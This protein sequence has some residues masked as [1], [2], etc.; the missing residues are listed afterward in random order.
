MD[1]G[2]SGRMELVGGISSKG[3]AFDEGVKYRLVET[4]APAGSRR[5]TE[6]TVFEVRTNGGTSE[7]STVQVVP[8][9]GSLYI[10]DVP[11]DTT[12]FDFYKVDRRDKAPLAGASFSLTLDTSAPS[13]LKEGE[14][15]PEGSK[16]FSASS[17]SE[18]KVHFSGLYAGTY[19]LKETKAPEADGIQYVLNSSEYKVEV[20]EREDGKLAVHSDIDA[21]G[22][23]IVN[24]PEG[25]PTSLSITKRVAKNSDATDNAK[26]D[27]EPFKADVFNISIT[28]KDG[29]DITKE[30]TAKIGANGVERTVTPTWVDGSYFYDLQRDETLTISDIPAGEYTI[31]EYDNGSHQ[32]SF[33]YRGYPYLITVAGQET[34]LRQTNPNDWNSL[35][36]KDYG[37]AKVE[38]K[39]NEETKVEIVNTAKNS[40]DFSLRGLKKILGR[41]FAEG[42]DFDIELYNAR[43]DFSYDVADLIETVTASKDN[44]YSFG[45]TKDNTITDADPDG[46]FHFTWANYWDPELVGRS[47]D[48]WFALKEKD[49][50]AE[51]TDLAYD[52][53]VYFIKVTIGPDETGELYNV[54][55][56][57]KKNS[58]DAAPVA[59]G[60]YDSREGGVPE[61]VVSFTN[62]MA[63]GNLMLQKT[64]DG[65]G[66][67]SAIPAGKGA[68]GLFGFTV[69]GLNSSLG[70]ASPVPDVAEVFTDKDGQVV[71]GDITYTRVGT[72]YYQIS[73]TTVPAGFTKAADVYAKVEVTADGAT[74]ALTAV[75]SYGSE[76]AAA[77]SESGITVDN[78]SSYTGTRLTLNVEKVLKGAEPASAEGPFE[79]VLSEITEGEGVPDRL[80]EEVKVQRKGAG[81]AAFPDIRYTEPGTHYYTVTETQGERG[82]GA[83]YD[84]VYDKKVYTVKVAVEP[85]ATEEAGVKTYNVLNA[86]PS[87]EYVDSGSADPESIIA[88]SITFTNTKV[89]DEEIS[90]GVKKQINGEDFKLSDLDNAFS[91]TMNSS[92]VDKDGQAVSTGTETI[93]LGTDGTGGF[94]NA[95][96]TKEDI[97]KTFTYVIKEVNGEG[98]FD[99][100]NTEYTVN[101]AVGSDSGT[102]AI[103]LTKTLSTRKVASDGTETVTGPTSYNEAAFMLNFNNALQSV[104]TGFKAEKDMAGLPDG[105]TRD[106]KFSL[107]G[108]YSGDVPEVPSDSELLSST[109][110]EI[111]NG[112]WGITFKD[113]EGGDFEVQY[114]RAGIYKYLIT[115][116]QL[117]SEGKTKDVYAND[118]ALIV[119]VTVGD[120]DKDGRLDVTKVAENAKA[121]ASDVPV[122][123]N[124][125]SSDSPVIPVNKVLKGRNILDSDKFTFELRDSADLSSQ[126]LSALTVGTD[127]K[128][129]FKDFVTFNLNQAGKTFS[130]Y[131]NELNGG[132]RGVSYSNAVHQVDI[133]VG[134]N[135]STGELELSYDY[136]TEGDAGAVRFENVYTAS[137]SFE[138]KGEKSLLNQGENGARMSLEGGE[139]EFTLWQDDGTGN[140]SQIGEAATNDASGK[141][142]FKLNFT[143]EDLRTG[144]NAYS[145]NNSRDITYYVK[146]TA[147]SKGG[148]SYADYVYKLKVRISAN[149]GK[150]NAES[151]ILDTELISCELVNSDGKTEQEAGVFAKLSESIRNFANGITGAANIGNV[152]VKFENSYQATGSYTI[153]F[154]KILSDEG[155]KSVDSFKIAL[156]KGSGSGAKT[157][158]IVLTKGE[159]VSRTFEYT[160]P[161]TYSYSWK[162]VLPDGVTKEDP[163]LNGVRYDTNTYSYN[164][165][166]ADVNH[167][168]KYTITADSGKTSNDGG[169]ESGELEES[170]EIVNEYSASGSLTINVNKALQNASLK[171]AANKFTFELYKDGS[172]TPETIEIGGEA[173]LSDEHAAAKAFEKIAYT[174]DDVG[175]HIYTVKERQTDIAGIALS[176]AEYTIA[177]S[178]SDAGNGGLKV[179]IE[180]IDNSGG[181][182]SIEVKEGRDV[183][184]DADFVNSYGANGSADLQIKKLIKEGDTVLTEGELDYSQFAF[185]LYELAVNDGGEETETEVEGNSGI[186]ADKDTGIATFHLNFT[187]ADAG[188]KKYRIKEDTANLL[189]GYS[190][191]NGGTVD[192][193]VTVTD[194]GDGTVTAEQKLEG[195]ALPQI[196]NI[197]KTDDVE[198]ALTATKK[199]NGFTSPRFDAEKVFTA[200]LK[201]DTENDPN[202]EREASVIYK[203]G[204]EGDKVF[205]FERNK[206]GTGNGLK[207]SLSDLAGAVSK[208]FYY[209]LYEK[210]AENDGVAYSDNIYA[211]KVHVYRKGN[212]LL[213]DKPE[214]KL[215]SGENTE[216]EKGYIQGLWERFT[217]QGAL[218]AVFENTFTSHGELTLSA[219]KKLEY[220]DSAAPAEGLLKEHSKELE[221]ARFNVKRG[222]EI[223]AI[224]RITDFNR[225]TITFYDPADETKEIKLSYGKEDTGKTYSYTVSEVS[226]AEGM[227]KAEDLSFD[228]TVYDR[229]NG[230]LEPVAGIKGADGA[231]TSGSGS[232]SGIFVNRLTRFELYKT[233]LA[234]EGDGK[235]LSGVDFTLSP[236]IGGISAYQTDSDGH[237]VIE[238]LSVGGNYTLTETAP[239][240]YSA[241]QP[242]KLHVEADG[243]VTATAA[244]GDEEYVLTD[245]S[246][247]TVKDPSSGSPLT[248]VKQDADGQELAGAEFR[249]ERTD[250]NESLFATKTWTTTEGSAVEK[251]DLLPVGSYTLTEIVTPVGYKT[252]EPVTITVDEYGEV[253]AT[254]DGSDGRV[255][256]PCT[257]NGDGEPYVLTLVNTDDLAL[258]LTK[259]W[260]DKV[261][262][263]ENY[264]GL[265]PESVQVNLYARDMVDKEEYLITEEPVTLSVANNW[266]YTFNTADYPAMKN[267]NDRFGHEGHE[268]KYFIKEYVPGGYSASMLD[269]AETEL[270]ETTGVAKI[271][272]KNSLNVETV[273]VQGR[274]IWSGKAP[275]ENDRPVIT[276]D[277]Y[278]SIKGGAESTEPYKSTQ[279]AI[280]M[281]LP[282]SCAMITAQMAQKSQNMSI[283]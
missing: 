169:T 258:Q 234:K 66:D 163:V 130:Y 29:N 252:M 100:D 34:A 38:V 247:I 171:D 236:E 156:T 264:Y 142:G 260:N 257:R 98:F 277:L 202:G 205:N 155:W 96:Y 135:E 140:L 245:T 55:T 10:G 166:V 192:V 188:E 200:V 165:T 157:E 207:Y 159:T 9:G 99:Y 120:S 138:I 80:T 111:T 36:T 216:I 222:S 176:Q 76:S 48:F 52:Q 13:L 193:V 20:I 58:G 63:T 69:T 54:A 77:A 86:V 180:K 158:E 272:L 219:E 127:G 12:E 275:N 75:T 51:N 45:F 283:P 136:K 4:T 265:R 274:K 132:V 88:D 256:V 104:S 259:V 235:P 44:G 124:T 79:F 94:E 187:E 43:S 41:D 211:V 14:S 269:E 173:G 153:N 35:Q 170:F 210:K 231:V 220:A 225:G 168:G 1:L 224:G 282:V 22:R 126:P 240:G 83:D 37:S 107:Y 125:Y 148:V 30:A 241:V 162:E 248:I 223:V 230:V 178:V 95:K 11:L 87:Y 182:G 204:E 101:V 121:G 68:E 65:S 103:K 84:I 67:F 91:F 206:D 5:N 280:A 78:S 28:D 119:T 172:D 243:K 262:D 2:S 164:V 144:E 139:Y 244:E 181:A 133:T 134:K 129:Q 161:G 194:N 60:T 255:T 42:E 218:D 214:I 92:Y 31:R 185:T 228:V 16:A 215:I 19:I 199:F 261:N 109:T 273:T 85:K 174:L 40:T 17:D 177:V 184:V 143:A 271:F 190:A 72:Y 113:A 221:N 196:V 242:I 106:F 150:G 53:S 93:G 47:R 3:W 114:D 147:G 64:V 201:P 49:E 267:K 131:I 270:N 62:V 281:S 24:S 57:Y 268:L 73:E 18:G 208:D 23:Q 8:N 229:G 249:L 279:V 50:S 15:I 198:V 152:D 251:I 151:G 250:G 263:T 97:G 226:D 115:E 276:V 154:T 33:N 191:L 70:T 110:R 146:E 25:D 27:G 6:P 197:L 122:F 46:G 105:E 227:V 179:A 21:E 160:E 61:A 59:I 141:F 89:M 212:E 128:G 203:A 90:F 112:N 167:E 175:E 116:E 239:E 246:R 253:S 213:A 81:K 183:S 209:R 32:K 82:E 56:I 123:T 237:L 74:G 233:S 71:W 117:I 39:Q 189:D 186:K 26:S 7:D 118:T 232:W 137:G 149:A 278:R 266:T 217:G 102:G 254:K 145:E 108:P 195:S 238:G